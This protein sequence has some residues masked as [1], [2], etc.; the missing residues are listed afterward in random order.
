MRPEVFRV[1]G[2][3]ADPA[4]GRVVF[5]P[6]KALWNLGLLGG[7]LVLGP[8]YFSFSGLAV[9]LVLTYMT[10]LLGHSAGMHRRFIHRAFDCPKWLERF[11]V[12]LG[13]LVG[14]AGPFAI[15][16]IHDLR[17]WAQREPTCHDFFSHRR[18]LMVDAWWQ[19]TSRFEFERPPRFHIEPEFAGDRFY[20]WLER[21]WMLQQVP[22][23]ALLFLVGG[24]SWVVWGVPVRVCVS[25]IGHW[26]VTYLTHNPGPGRWHVPGAGVQ[27][28]DLRGYG[29]VTM[30]ECW[31]NNHHAF[32]ESARIGLYPGETDPTWQVIRF[33]KRL[34]LVSRVGLPRP[35]Q[36]R[37]DIE[38]RVDAGISQRGQASCPDKAWAVSSEET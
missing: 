1:D 11:L 14:M 16:R 12:Y 22:L 28:T 31:H 18:S 5:T 34:G 23:A 17:D 13:T 15:L 20:V 4:S 30:G 19:L 27:A 9:F 6:T 24:W 38:K 32:P 37:G 7:S 35:E 26:V 36:A 21:T 3:G 10:L 2:A 33:L 8:I 25:V 29:L